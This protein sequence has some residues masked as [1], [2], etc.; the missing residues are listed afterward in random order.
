MP[1]G[2][3]AVGLAGTPSAAGGPG[4][5]LVRAQAGG[6]FRAAREERLAS[7]SWCHN[8]A[9]RDRSGNSRWSLWS[10]DSLL[11]IGSR[12]SLLS[13][14]SVGSVLS[15]GPIGSAGSFC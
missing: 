6:K 12:G 10:E 8:G 7:L 11:S 1:K 4:G 15:I 13:I 2:G 5:A 14:G 3:G 9:T